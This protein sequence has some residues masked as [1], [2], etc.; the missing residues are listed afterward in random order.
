[1]K[2]KIAIFGST[3]SI[4]ITTLTIIKKNKKNFNISLLTTNSN[5][6]KIFKQ[7]K[8]FNVKNVIITNKQIFLK[9]KKTFV[10][11]KINLYD[12]FENFNK[13]FRKKIDYTINAISGIDGLVPTL[14]V[15]KFTNKIAIANKESIIC[16]WNLIR[17][18]LSKNNTT[19]IP[20]DSEHFSIFQLIKNSNVRTIKKIILTASG[21][22][23]LNKKNFNKIKIKDALKHPNWKMG[24]KI[25]IDSSTLMNKVFEVIEAKKIF[26]LDL[27]KIDILI[28]PNS[29]VHAIV[30]FKNGIIKFLAHE[31]KMEIPIINSIYDTDLDHKYNTK[32]LS[33]NKI[34]KLN[35][36]K[37]NIKYFRT[38]NILKLIP[39][40]N[41]LFETVI[42]SVN[43]ELVRM[44]LNREITYDKLLFYLIKIIKFK[45]FKKYC[46]VR[47]NSIIDIIKVNK[48]AKNFVNS[49][50]KKNKI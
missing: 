25:T 22:P 18:E 46:N 49:Y 7:S 36:S 14:K 50:V 43:D 28:N 33:I 11:N 19:F 2:K 37:P 21:G 10:K 16:G 29:Y 48:L 20:V 4:G 40:K 35:L 39:A 32:P 23:F 12:N 15:I 31:T 13:I 9:W 6:L 47:P 5:A 8:E 26:N 41:S 34:N 17:K 3:G 27:D 1:M 24:K 30:I 38:L 44:F 42:I 45:K